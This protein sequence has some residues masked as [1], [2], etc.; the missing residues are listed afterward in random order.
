MGDS[1]NLRIKDFINSNN[2]KYDFI[3]IPYH[4]NYLKRLDDLLENTNSKYGVIT[5]SNKEG[6]EDKTLDILD[7]YNVKKYLTRDGSISISSNGE[8]IKVLQ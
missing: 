1:E 7:K 2:S 4:G 3:K 5:C 8:K 6:C